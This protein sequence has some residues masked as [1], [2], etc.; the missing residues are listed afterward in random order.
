[1]FLHPGSLRTN[2]VL[3]LWSVPLFLCLQGE[4]GSCW[5]FSVIGNVEGQWFVRKGALISLSE[6]GTVCRDLALM[7]K[8]RSHH[9]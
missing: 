3:S 5:A 9:G 6:Q 8:I 1:M 2:A 7:G 4:C